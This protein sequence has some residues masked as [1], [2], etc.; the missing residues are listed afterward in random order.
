[1]HFLPVPGLRTVLTPGVTDVGDALAAAFA[2]RGF[3]WVSGGPGT[4]KTFAVHASAGRIAGLLPLDVRA[5]PAPEDFRAA[6]HRALGLAGAAPADPG[7]ADTLIRRALATAQ[8]VVLVDDAD[9]LSASCFEYLR[10]LHDATPGGLCVVLVAG[11]GG[12]R[13]LGTRRMLAS[14]T[15]DRVRVLPL[16]QEEVMGAIPALH[17]LW[18]S[19]DPGDLQELDFRFAQGSLRR[20]VLVTHHARRVLAATGGTPDAHLLR[21]VAGRIGRAGRP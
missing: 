16:N 15:T 17:P 18:S 2:R 10:F 14:R 7:T 8:G 6:L 3:L 4:G 1:M 11:E 20:W 13:S 19:V 9:R 12:E 21:I 5:H